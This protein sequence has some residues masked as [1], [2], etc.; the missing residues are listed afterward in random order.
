M[1]GG[2][3]LLIVP[4]PGA[5][6]D[7]LPPLEDERPNILLIVTDDQR[8]TGTLGVMPETRRIFGRKG[9]HFPN[10]YATTPLCCPSRASI[11]TGQY[12][13][14]HGL[15]T[16]SDSDLPQERTLQRYLDQ[17]G[18]ETAIFGKY[19]N[20]WTLDRNPP[21]FDE[22]AIFAKS[23]DAYYGGQWNVNG[24]VQSVPTY[25]TNF[26]RNQALQ[27]TVKTLVPPRPW[28]LILTPPAPHAP[29]QPESRYY[30]AP[31]PKWD[32]PPSV[33]ERDRSDKPPFF[34][35]NHSDLT[36]ARNIRRKQLR[37][38]MSVDDMVEAIFDTL[39]TT[40]QADNTFAIFL[41]DNGY[42]WNEH[43]LIGSVLSK[44]N[45]YRES[46]RV[47]LFLRWP[48]HFP[49]GLN[50]PRLVATIDILPTILDALE[51]DPSH[52]LDG[53]SLLD[54]WTRDRMLVE[55]HAGARELAGDW[56]S[57]VTHRSIY[58]EY[59]GDDGSV[60][61]SEYYD[62]IDDPWQLE[63]RFGSDG[64]P[65]AEDPAVAT[66]LTSDRVCVGSSCP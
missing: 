49:P 26:I 40:G 34:R 9:L 31:V 6:Q 28:F 61:F 56:A 43:G 27:F 32:P 21:H 48:G 5:A 14:N 30:N 62:L 39:K 35:R 7:P 23:A 25:A 65:D 52:P 45:P 47:P 11:L 10:A 15:E 64:F 24:Q 37:T 54:H 22:W 33:Y 4:V 36:K 53:R 58:T 50:D 19:L 17:A 51:I 66:E 16:N 63:N 60:G 12:V 2:L 18:Y 13:H 46:I 38:L 1:A 3:V 29:Y 57:S 20:G 59:Y 44:N 8:A 42:L 41:S 55:Y